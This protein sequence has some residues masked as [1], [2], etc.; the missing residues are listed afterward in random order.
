MNKIRFEKQK[1][2]RTDVVRANLICLIAV[3]L[4]AFTFPASDI[5]L[6]EFSIYVQPINYPTVP[7]GT[8]RL[9][10]TPTPYHD[11]SKMEYLVDCIDKIW[12]E[13]KL[14]RAA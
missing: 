3:A 10:F 12:L 7:K 5:L 9:R 2:A 4:F 8:E 13:L 14:S 11:D 1:L 6:N